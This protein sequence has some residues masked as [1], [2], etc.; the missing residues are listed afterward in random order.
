MSETKGPT[1]VH[2]TV[3]DQKILVE[4]ATRFERGEPLE[5]ILADIPEHLRPAIESAVRAQITGPE[6][7]AKLCMHFKVGAAVAGD[8]TIFTMM[9]FRDSTER[10]LLAALAIPDDRMME[11]AGIVSRSAEAFFKSKE[12]H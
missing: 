4:V 9:V 3:D 1:D 12:T 11:F 6:V 5:D 10:E 2:P 8:S 7:A